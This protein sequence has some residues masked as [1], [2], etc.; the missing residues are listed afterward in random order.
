VQGATVTEL[1]TSALENV[2]GEIIRPE[3][4]RYD[5]ARAIHNAGTDKHPALVVRCRDVA[6]VISVVNFARSSGLPLAVRGG[7]H[8]PAGFSSVDDGIVLDLSKMRGIKVD[9][10]A[11]T[12][13]VQG[14]C[15][16]G[17]VDHATHA[18]GLA[19]PGGV[20]STTG[21]GGL[22]LGGGT[23]HL[24]RSFGLTV[25]NLLEADVV[26]AEGTFVTANDQQND[27]LFWAL[28]G[29]GGNFGVVT[30]LTFRLHSVD[31]VVAGPMLWPLDQAAEALRMYEQL[32]AGAPDEL[33]GV[34]A[35]LVV[36]PGPPF[37]EDLHLK[38]VCGIVW[39]YTGPREG[40]DDVLAP[41]RAL[42]PPVFELVGPMPHPILQSMFDG[43]AG[44]GM[45]NYW[46]GD[47]LGE[48]TD[49]AIVKHVEY[50][51]TV[52]NVFSGVHLYPVDGVAGRVAPDATAWNY[53]DARWAE[54][55][56]AAD[57]AP[58]SFD[59]LK[60]WVV[61]SW[62]LLHPF[63][64]GGG[65]VNFLVEEGQERVQASYRDNYVRLAELKARYDPTNL[66]RLNQNIE[67]AG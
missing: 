62:D 1:D 43:I 60:D 53:R 7:G 39:C 5:E 12:A 11:R 32:L 58:A 63:S 33:T 57:P 20:V 54:V 26:L 66:F 37:P 42:G 16:W 27:D 35:F 64:M 36:P 46:R 14:G 24:T 59:S 41:A 8:N 19:A 15:T 28:R 67:P 45:H 31:M 4:D 18:F 56:F 30:S 38:T 22:T 34:F 2:R 10:I 48:L 40:A 23:G 6:D 44:P 50:G 51:S 3:D 65:Y 52:P 9:P 29:G 47:F 13:T 61:E 21:V 55:I 25:D 49:E 17:D